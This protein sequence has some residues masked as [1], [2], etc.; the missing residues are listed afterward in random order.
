MISKDELINEA[1]LLPVE[2]RLQLVDRLLQSLNFINKDIDEQ[3]MIEAE[4]RV[5]EIENGKIET[6]SGEDV[7]QRL[8]DRL[9][10]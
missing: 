7:F 2:I 8:H 9:K 6:V 1:V 10:K 3:W 4:R 5:A